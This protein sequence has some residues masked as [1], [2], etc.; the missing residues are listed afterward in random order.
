MA[1]DDSHECSRGSDSSVRRRR[2]LQGAGVTG[3]I[4]LA[5]C[6]S[7]L[8]GSGGDGVEYWTL[9]GGGDGDVMKSMVDQINQSDE[10]DIQVN[11]QRIPFEE[12]YDNLYTSLT[13][14]ERPDIAV[15]HA[16]MMEEFGDHLSPVT[17]DIGTDPYVDDLAQRG[18]VDGDQLAVPLD[19]HPLGLYYNKDIFEEAGLDPESPPTTPDE[20]QE[21]ADA[22]TE[23]TDHWALQY[24]SGGAAVSYLRMGMVARGGSVLTDDLEPGFD[25][26]DGLAV[27]EYIHD[28]VHE[29][30]WAPDDS[31]TGWEAWNRG[32]VGMIFEGTWHI[33]VVR[34]NDYEWGMTEPFA[35][36]GDS[37][38]T[39]GNSHMLVI[40][41][42]ENRDESKR[43]QAVETIRL[44]TQEYN[45]QWGYDAGHL[46]AS[47]EA[48][49]SDEL[50][51]SDIWDKTLETF[52]GMVE[53]GQAVAPPATPNNTAYQE[54]IY[55]YLDDMRSGNLTPEEAVENAADGVRSV[56]E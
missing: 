53:N 16:D 43:E 52:Y 38:A 46:P 4:G 10:H 51:E 39:E 36:P 2:F 7:L 35:F 24:H 28:W 56:F 23:N 42:D 14:D 9:F 12:Y 19:T 44:L 50:R 33:G 45:G 54:Q 25:N 40:P 17:D 8:G 13:G 26:E 3:T 11:R 22:I 30:E 20:F 41:E 18:V 6:T 48:L 47:Q 49:D 27:T 34:E 32:D 29:H 15:L 1:V 37:P 31:D 21:A 55:Q 5:G